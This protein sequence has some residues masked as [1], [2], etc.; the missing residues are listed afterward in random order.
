MEYGF[1]RKVAKILFALFT[2]LAF[3]VLAVAQRETGSIQGTV[4]DP[5]G[6]VVAGAKITVK[7]VGTGTT[8]EATTGPSGLYNVT[9]LQPGPYDVTVESP[10]FAAQTH[11]IAVT[12]G[13]TASLDVKMAVGKEVTVVEVTATPVAVET[14]SQELTTTVSGRQITELPSLTRNPYD[15]VVT[16]PNV[17]TGTQDLNT[18]DVR[19]AGVTIN[20]GRS[21]STDILLD[22]GENVDLFVSGVG[23]QVPLDS[24][25]EFSVITN[26]FDSSYG[27]ASGGIVN[28]A[29]KGG[30]NDFHGTLYEFNRVSALTA[31]TYS[32]S[33][34]GT[35]KPGYTRNQFG[36]SIG[37]PIIKN[38]LFFF[39][40]LELIRVRSSAAIQSL[41]ADPAFI[42]ASAANT[43]AFFAAWGPALRPGT[44]LV[45]TL[46]AC[47]ALGQPGACGSGVV[48]YD[49]AG[50]VL[51]V[52]DHVSY[53]APNDSGGGTP[54]NTIMTVGRIDWNITDK[55]MLY[56]R[57]AL[58]K[59]NDFNGSINSSPYPGFDTGQNVMNQ[60]MMLNLTH[61]FTPNLVSQSK[62]VFNR[63]N[64]V[65]PLGAQPVGPT[66]Y[67]TDGHG[68]SLNNI[69]VDFPG[70]S[71]RTPGNA[72]P[73]GGPQNLYQFYEDLNWTKG[74]HSF[75][76][77]GSYVNTKD[78]RVFGAYEEATIGLVRSV[79]DDQTALQNLFD[80]NS[81]RFQVA[82]F[83]QGN[84]PCPRDA[85][86]GAIIPNPSCAL[87]GPLGPPN[88]ARSNLYNDLSFYAMD[89]WRIHPRLTLNLG[90]RWEY[91]GVQHNRNSN[92]DSNFYFGSAACPA[93]APGCPG[94]ALP[95]MI[96]NGSAQ[97]ANSSPVGGLWN[98]QYH[99]FA[100]R[101]GFAWDVFGNG[102]TSL[103]GGYGIAYER[104]FG[105]VT[106][107][108]IQNPPNY[109]VVQIRDTPIVSTN[110][111][112]LSGPG[113]Q[114]YR[115]TSLRHVDQNIPTAYNQ[116]W[117][118]TLEHELMKD[119]L[120]SVGYTGSKGTH[121]YDIK[122][123]GNPWTGCMYIG[124]PYTT[125][126]DCTGLVGN[127]AMN[128]QYAAINER[129]ADGFSSYHA[130]VVS[131]RSSNFRGWG[132][133]FNANYTFSHNID[134]LSTTFSE[135][136]NNFNLGYMDPFNPAQ[137]KG[138]ADSDARHQFV[139]SAI[140]DVPLGKS[141][142]GF[143]KQVLGG[144]S[145]APIYQVRTGVPFTVWDCTNGVALCART[146]FNSTPSNH[147]MSDQINLGGN[148][149]TLITL[150]AS[151]A[152]ADPV[153]GLA[154]FGTCNAVFGVSPTTVFPCPYPASMSGRN[155]FV[156]PGNWN[157]NLGIYKNFKITE[158]WTLQFRNEWY[159][160]FNHHNFF[161]NG[162][163]AVDGGGPAGTTI[164]G[165]KGGFG[166]SADE[167]R[168]I[169]FALKLIF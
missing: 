12:V 6:A 48:G 121:L 160:V 169:Q 22:G 37:G 92:L 13:G 114:L 38:K 147:A 81:Q 155:M 151:T 58:Y 148:N 126:P 112:L 43:Q 143:A 44:T 104:N 51:P 103:R 31:N 91:Y 2:V 36:G 35:P 52:F 102:K 164:S 141:S 64:L 144:W 98:P 63:L 23:Q 136:N 15:F 88:F 9:S 116:F 49:A 163:A 24:V 8:R 65:Q 139:F 11:R 62:F 132:L 59:E 77:G 135:S 28:V 134:N 75:K 27:R 107:N 108:V 99:N 153:F 66:L 82:L 123:F 20:G 60:N 89:S 100:P 159:N 53:V 34:S 97:L 57:Y 56:G 78:N 165:V 26:N 95:D 125:G 42:A 150:P 94:Y 154:D 96:A 18:N 4:T 138:S 21:A 166:T 46:T 131:L 47:Q 83:P 101:I 167:R 29:T 129:G 130:L 93:I 32:N 17:G 113:P 111:G 106:F 3:S 67:M 152:Y 161:V 128:L 1:G 10:G 149:F 50:N 25:G 109:A 115:P 122:A 39:G 118:L 16:A 133:T 140:W 40:N 90:V 41:V 117:S 74:K 55:T 61:I 73:F 156:G 7:G 45:G 124:G 168:F 30:T 157:L 70:Y 127:V 69:F 86:S 120:I 19:G 162:S 85:A 158:R 71:A 146:V 145:L 80:G 54:Q 110:L 68:V 87:N 79:E 33:A 76:F 72:I 142:T 137:D 119:T 105:N 14:Q 84:F 5:S